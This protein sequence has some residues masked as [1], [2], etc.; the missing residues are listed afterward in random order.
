MFDA[1]LTGL[2]NREV[3]L[4]ASIGTDGPGR[5]WDRISR[6]AHEIERLGFADRVTTREI[7][8]FLQAADK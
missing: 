2:G 5:P 4:L 7:S 1:T 8:R 3:I 6:I